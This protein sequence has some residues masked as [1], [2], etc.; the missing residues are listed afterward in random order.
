MILFTVN[1]LVFAVQSFQTSFVNLF[2]F[3]FIECIT[4]KYTKRVLEKMWGDI[5]RAV[6]QKCNDLRKKS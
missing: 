1:D 4:K 3:L 2:F 6:N 5:R